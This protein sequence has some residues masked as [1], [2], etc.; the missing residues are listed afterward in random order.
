MT[1]FLFYYVFFFFGLLAGF[2]IACLP[3]PKPEKKLV[4]FAAH[5]EWRNTNGRPVGSLNK[6]K[7]R[8]NRT[9]ITKITQAGKPIILE[10]E[11]VDSLEIGVVKYKSLQEQAEDRD[12]SKKEEE[13]AMT[14]SLSKHFPIK[15]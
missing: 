8:R 13:E 1:S 12:I 3:E 2:L 11:D 5:P 10:D 9:H 4:G 6:K 15:N 7:K 14:E